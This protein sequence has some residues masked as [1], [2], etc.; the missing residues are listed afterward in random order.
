MTTTDTTPSFIAGPW[1]VETLE[2]LAALTRVRV[3]ANRLVREM[4][5]YAP[6]LFEHTRV[7]LQE[8]ISQT[9]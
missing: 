5:A 2:R 3:I 1:E 8:A 7:E 6:G 9:F 4:D